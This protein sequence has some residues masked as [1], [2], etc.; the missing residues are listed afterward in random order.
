LIGGVVMSQETGEMTVKIYAD[1]NQRAVVQSDDLPWIPSPLAGVERRMLERDGDEVARAT[2]IVRYAPNSYFDPHTHDA[3][4]EFLVLDGVF[5]D[6]MGDYPAGMYV[7]NP[8][9]SKHKPHTEEGC[10]ILVKLRQMDSGDDNFVRIDTNSAEWLPGTMEGLT[11][12]P[13][14]ERN[15]E[16]V[17]LVRFA[18]GAHFGRHGHPG[19]EE[20]FVLDG[21]LEDEHGRY[22]KGTWLRSPPGSAHQPFSTDGCTIYVKTGHLG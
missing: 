5:S 17:A 6:E 13:L 19:G 9:G 20:I 11:I 8:P 12:M 22:P 18:P 15:S 3:G 21:V 14:Y 1:L 2:T 16:H 10:T 7:R 4:E